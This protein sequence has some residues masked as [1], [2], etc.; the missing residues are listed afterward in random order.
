LT[1]FVPKPID[2]VDQ[3][4]ILMLT[5]GRPEKIVRSIA[6]LNDQAVDKDKIDIWIYVDNDDA[7]MAEF[8][9]SGW[10]KEIDIPI[11]W[12]IGSRPVT[13]GDAFNTLWRMSSNAGLYFG[14]PDDYVVT[15]DNWDISMRDA[16]RGL[17]P[18]RIAAGY[19]PDPLM[20]E[21]VITVMV[22]TAE[23]VNQVGHFIV[24]YFPYWY[25]DKWLQQ[26][27]D[28]VDRKI[29]V[30]VGIC[31]MDNSKGK[32][33]RMWDM[34]FW[35]DFFHHLLVERVDT[36]K[37][38]IDLV[39]HEDSIAKSRAIEFLHEKMDEILI[40][41]EAELSPEELAAHE[42]GYSDRTE[43]KDEVYEQ[44]LAQAQNHLEE[45][46]PQIV[47]L[48]TQHLLKLKQKL[49]ENTINN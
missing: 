6:S 8:I 2:D 3:I 45:M 48:K 26:I 13:H 31:P 16:F 38:I 9:E 43:V 11:H 39:F 20:P 42:L 41:T 29:G 23:W 30:P 28:M 34:P 44:A 46:M 18:D 12:H 33:R 5:R 40:E 17:P 22:E 21:G 49:I 19:L 1:E 47:Q 4:N 32:I 37:Q 27:A 35:A 24:P 7:S 10:D 14:F 36:A 15:T 25:G